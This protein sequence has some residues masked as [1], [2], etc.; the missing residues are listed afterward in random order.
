MIENKMGCNASVCTCNQT[1]DLVCKDRRTDGLYNILDEPNTITCQPIATYGALRDPL[2]GT[3]TGSIRYT[4]SLFQDI[5]SD[6]LSDNLAYFIE[7][8]LHW[9]VSQFMTSFWMDSLSM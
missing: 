2:Y 1:E 3:V 6:K 9:N 8:V 5:Y 4:Q 7:N